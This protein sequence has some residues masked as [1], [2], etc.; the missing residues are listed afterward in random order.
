[1]IVDHLSSELERLVE[2]NY[3]I[4]GSWSAFTLHYPFGVG[5]FPLEIVCAGKL[6]EYICFT[7]VCCEGAQ[8][9]GDVSLFIIIQHQSIIIITPLLSNTELYTLLIKNGEMYLG[10]RFGIE[11]G[12]LVVIGVGAS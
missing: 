12:W 6:D 3:G 9:D 10:G 11:K 1:M 5:C 8:V 4:D 7:D 2:C